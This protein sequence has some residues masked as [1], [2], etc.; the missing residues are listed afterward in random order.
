MHTEREQLVLRISPGVN[1]TWDVTES[2]GKALASF[3]SPQDACAWAIELA[4]KSRARIFVE[5][6]CAGSMSVGPQRQAKGATPSFSI[7]V[8]VDSPHEGR[9]GLPLRNRS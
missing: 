6:L 2:P 5:Q 1:K 4:R 9:S 8:M 7:P 3:A